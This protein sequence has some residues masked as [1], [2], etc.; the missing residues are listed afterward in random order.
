MALTGSDGYPCPDCGKRYSRVVDAVS[1]WTQA[2]PNALRTISLREAAAMLKCSH[3]AVRLAANALGLDTSL[4]AKD[5]AFLRRATADNLRTRLGLAPRRRTEA[6]RE[7]ARRSWQALR[8]DP[9]RYSN[10]LE[11]QR[12]RHRQRWRDEPEFRRSRLESLRRWRLKRRQ[13]RGGPGAQSDARG[14]DQEQAA[15]NA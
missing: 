1:C 9:V 3:E 2:V 7:R 5:P 11:R 10:Y 12:T 13:G 15:S 6:D 14:D 8:V 4:T